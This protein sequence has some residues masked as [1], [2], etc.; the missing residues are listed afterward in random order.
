M[1]TAFLGHT[2][3]LI[4]PT[5]T[6]PDQPSDPD[7]PTIPEPDVDG[8]GVEIIDGRHIM[9]AEYVPETTLGIT[10]T[11]PAMLAFP[12]DLTKIVISS[13]AEFDE[14]EVL[15]PPTE[16]DRLSCGVAIRTVGKMH[17]VEIHCKPSS[18][19]LLPYAICAAD[20][21]NYSSPGT[22]IHPCTIGVRVGNKYTT[23]KGC[24]LRSIRYEFKDVKSVADCVL[25]FCGAERTPWSLTDYA[26]GG[27]NATPSTAQ[28][29][30]ISSLSDIKYD[31]DAAES[32]GFVIDSLKF[33]FSNAIEPVLSTSGILDSKIVGWSYGAMEIQ[34]SLGI[35][36]T[37]PAPQDSVLAGNSHTLSFSLGGKTFNF[38][39]IKWIRDADLDAD[40]G[41]RI[42][43][44]LEA[45]PR[46]V[47][48]SFA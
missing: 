9:Y 4:A 33:G 41:S 18:L 28:P 32:K 2:P 27:S 11:A 20:T 39:E 3:G 30:K 22:S 17:T 6:G 47:R 5:Q 24:V 38:S 48:V 21:A 8:V 1:Y 45:A 13:G 42:G 36:L 34:L 10:P 23:I 37:D 25:T 40:P 26:F 35:S 7:E 31:R 44:E 12:G 15:K 19:R 14:F 43:M 46:A 29:F 16:S